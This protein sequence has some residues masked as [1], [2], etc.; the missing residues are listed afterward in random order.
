MCFLAINSL[1]LLLNTNVLMTN[2]MFCFVLC[3]LI[4]CLGRTPWRHL[5]WWVLAPNSP[6][7]CTTEE[8]LYP[9]FEPTQPRSGAMVVSRIITI[10]PTRTQTPTR[11]PLLEVP[12]QM[13]SLTM[14]EQTTP[15]PSPPL[16]WMQ[17]LLVAWLHYLARS[18][19]LVAHLQGSQKSLTHLLF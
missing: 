9:L 18:R 13:T 2:I 12:T 1:T 11:V 6:S 19:R 5:T 10:H 17:P 4:M 3:R 16:T 14:H 15:T 8:R 7:G